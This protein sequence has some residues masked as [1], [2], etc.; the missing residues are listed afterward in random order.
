VAGMYYSTQ[1]KVKRKMQQD[2]PEI[3]AEFHTVFAFLATDFHAS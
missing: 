3:P 1:A 2:P